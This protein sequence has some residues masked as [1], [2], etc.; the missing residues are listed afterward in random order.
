[1]VAR[2]ILDWSRSSVSRIWWG[3]ALNYGS[4]VPVFTYLKKDHQLFAVSGVGGV[5]IYFYW[6]AYRQPFDEPAKRMELRDKLNAI[7]GVFIPEDGINRRPSI[8][9]LALQPDES[10]AQFFNIY[11][12]FIAQ[13]KASQDG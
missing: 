4:F 13:I 8:P 2:R 7:P 9:L 10:L 5:E 6:Y 1:M 11:S 12:W 3:K